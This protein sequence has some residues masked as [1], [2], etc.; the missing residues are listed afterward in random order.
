MSTTLIVAGIG[1]SGSKSTAVNFTVVD[2]MRP[3]A[4]IPNEIV[5]KQVAI[6]DVD[7][8]QVVN[9]LGEPVVRNQIRAGVTLNPEEVVAFGSPETSYVKDGIEHDLDIAKQQLLLGGDLEISQ[10]KFKPLKA[11]TVTKSE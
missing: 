9:K 11:L 2:G 7:G 10:P 6:L 5:R 4:W 3:W 1:G 8:N